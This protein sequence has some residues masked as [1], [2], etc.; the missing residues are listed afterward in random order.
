M[1]LV[2]DTIQRVADSSS[3][4]MIRGESG[5]GK[6]LTARAI[7]SLGSR[8]EKPFVSINCAALPENLIEAELFGH[9][10]GAFTDARAARAGHIQLAHT[11]T[12]FLDEI[13]TLG[14][15]GEEAAA[16]S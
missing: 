13:A 7:V 9:E 3:T 5:T 14:L 4:V 10:K 12:L 1:R 6:E 16:R 15:R 11:G 2:Y 8:F